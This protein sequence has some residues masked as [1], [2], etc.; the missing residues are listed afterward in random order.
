MSD[1]RHPG[2]KEGPS[3]EKMAVVAGTVV[4]L[5]LLG[6]MFYARSGDEAASSSG[7]Q[8]SGP[9]AVPF[10]SERRSQTGLN[11][12]RLPDAEPA[13]SSTFSSG[14]LSSVKAE[15]L[16]GGSPAAASP[17]PAP[18]PGPA[19]AP[20][21]PE[22]PAAEKPV[23]PKE[24]AAAGMP[25][26][27]A[28]L[29]RL[30]SD[31]SLLT[32]AISKLLDHPRIL[33]AILNNKLVVD[34]LM[35]R[36]DAKR[37]CADAGALQAGLSSPSAGAYMNQYAPL[38]KAVLARPD[39]LAAVAGSEMG[40]RMLDCPSASGLAHN[41]SGLMAIAAANPQAVGLVSDPGI[42]QALSST[43]QGAALLGGVQSSIGASGAQ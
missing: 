18:A 22:K 16:P 15:S 10:S 12:V 28:G 25:T 5:L 42:A 29:K 32:G 39:T 3:P 20:P 6:W 26:D 19:A 38:V 37:D 4:G 36:D 2:K 13:S 35:N 31:P 8:E 7:F 14:A 30:G 34:A 43:S 27:A 40:S 41:P 33:A 24:I 21:A 17:A 1:W 11:Y 23:D 9:G